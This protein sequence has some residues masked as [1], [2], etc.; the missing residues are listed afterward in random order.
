MEL[1]KDIPNFEGL[2]Q[3]STDGEIRSLEHIRKNGTGQYL[4]T[5]KTLKQKLT[6]GYLSIRLSKNGVAKT[7]RV[8]RL[9]ASTFIPN[10]DNKRTVNHING[11][12]TDNRVENLEWATDK[13]QA[14]HRHYVLNVPTSDCSACH[15]ANKRKVLRS[16]GKI[17]NSIN[18]ARED[19]GKPNAHITEVC[20]GK[21][22]SVYGYGFSYMEG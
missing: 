12:K 13:E 22:K 11:I 10:P 6:N 20:Q 2:Y 14:I 15:I 17:Y 1:W 16:D 18:E 3:A 21:L 9:I 19:L 7:Y 5:G 8:N 4:H